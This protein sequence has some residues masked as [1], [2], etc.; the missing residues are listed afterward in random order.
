MSILS[1][2]IDQNLVKTFRTLVDQEIRHGLTKK[3]T[4][5]KVEDIYF[6]G[7]DD[8]F[9]VKDS[10]VSEKQDLLYNNCYLK[11]IYEAVYIAIRNY[12][13]NN[14]F[15]P[16]H[17]VAIL[18]MAIAPFIENNYLS[19]REYKFKFKL[20][21][22]TTEAVYNFKDNSIKN[23][24]DKEVENQYGIDMRKQPSALKIILCAIGASKEYIE[25]LTSCWNNPKSYNEKNAIDQISAEP[26]FNI[27]DKLNKILHLINKSVNGRIIN[28]YLDIP[29]YLL[30]A[31]T[32]VE[33]AEKLPK[34]KKPPFNDY[35]EFKNNDPEKR[36]AAYGKFKSDATKAINALRAVPN[37]IDLTI[38]KLKI[39]NGTLNEEIAKM[40]ATNKIKK[41]L[42][43][44]IE[45]LIWYKYFGPIIAAGNVMG[46]LDLW[47][48]LK[49]NAFVETCKLVDENVKLVND[50]KK[51]NDNY[52]WNIANAIKK[53][54][55]NL[56]ITDLSG[57]L[58]NDPI[59][60]DAPPD[61]RR[62]S[63]NYT[64][65]K[66]TPISYSF[67]NL[68]IE[69]T[70]LSSPNNLQ[71]KSFF[72]SNQQII[73]ETPRSSTP[74]QSNRTNKQIEPFQISDI[75]H[76]HRS[77]NPL[78]SPNS[79]NNS[80]NSPHL[81]KTEAADVD[82][83]DLFS[84]ASSEEREIQKQKELYASGAEFTEGHTGDEMNQ[85]IHLESHWKFIDETI[86]KI[87]Q[88]DYEKAKELF[89]DSRQGI[90]N[91]DDKL[92]ANL[93]QL[94]EITKNCSKTI[95][96]FLKNDWARKLDPKIFSVTL[97]NSTIDGYDYNT[98]NS[99]VNFIKIVDSEEKKIYKPLEDNFYNINRE[100]YISLGL[101]NEISI[102]HEKFQEFKQMTLYDRSIGLPNFNQLIQKYSKEA[103]QRFYNN[104]WDDKKINLSERYQ[105]EIK[106][107]DGTK[108]NIENE[109]DQFG[110]FL[111][112]PNIKNV[113]DNKI[114]NHAIEIYDGFIKQWNA[115]IQE[116]YHERFK[117]Q[118]DQVQN[119]FTTNDL[120]D[121]K[122]NNEVDSFKIAHNIESI[123]GSVTDIVNTIKLELEA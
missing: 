1:D 53:Y 67:I 55:A 13:S 61:V 2:N 86:Y 54:A 24:S 23:K 123:I 9:G 103:L 32:L 64:S 95:N 52:G 7:K 93:P 40:Q 27:E 50:L 33:Y 104:C 84:N 25:M 88:I 70:L 82:M 77:N 69:N 11:Q 71:N 56:N 3:R 83:F 81:T 60:Y 21:N 35:E 89:N 14:E 90:F 43:T 47:S 68:P 17:L 34:K 72:L 119:Y 115:F 96:D 63:F 49:Q 48:S 118:V 111:Q 91:N 19:N 94:K 39:S 28:D 15:T 98:L 42:Y 75:N 74:T 51:A 29:K 20:K 12:E 38:F 113:I 110:L 117:V 114:K 65:P 108:D 105:N 106:E 41:F 99:Y 85:F 44:S 78:P 4:D 66:Q 59:C 100:F 92:K 36:K 79:S 45:I 31:S 6:I 37:I 87:I 16:K 80:L 116:N 18:C 102:I 5:N 30:F 10:K 97:I 58:N 101:N 76:L 57:H 26:T 22:T 107:I 109:S 62:T 112:I 120:E 121:L 8:I 122:A 46:S 73:A